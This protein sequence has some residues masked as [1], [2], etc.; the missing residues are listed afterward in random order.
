V[1]TTTPTAEMDAPQPAKSSKGTTVQE[2]A[3]LFVLPTVKFVLQDQ[4][5]LSV[6]LKLYG[7]ALYANLTAPL[8]VALTV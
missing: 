8:R 6:T 2:E 1:M 5:A 4:T 7:T 3:A